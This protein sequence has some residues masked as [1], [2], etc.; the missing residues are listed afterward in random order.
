MFVC[1]IPNV[2]L[3]VSQDDVGFKYISNKKTE[4]PKGYTKIAK[5]NDTQNKR[6]DNNRTV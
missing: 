1:M 3:A 2:N 6:Q 4:I 5:S